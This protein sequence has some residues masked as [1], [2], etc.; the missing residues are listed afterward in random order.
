VHSQN[1][2]EI[3]WLAVL[4]LCVYGFHVQEWFEYT[5]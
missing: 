2:N 1:K 4:D 3:A 5:V